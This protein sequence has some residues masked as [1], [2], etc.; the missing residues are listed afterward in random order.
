MSNKP[1]LTPWFPAGVKPVHDGLYQ[2]RPVRRDWPYDMHWHSIWRNGD[3]CGATALGI[4]AALDYEMRGFRGC[5]DGPLEW[6]GL[7]EKPQ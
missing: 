1:K 6:R 3:W 4:D 2:V 5:G 7:A